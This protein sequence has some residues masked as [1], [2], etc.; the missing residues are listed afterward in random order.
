MKIIGIIPARGGSK[1]VIRKNIRIID[2]LPLIA[3]TI[4]EA[5]KSELLDKVVVSTEDEEISKISKEFGVQVIPR[6][7]SLSADDVQNTEV[8]RHVLECLGGGFSHIV[9]LQPTSPLRGYADIDSCIKLLLEEDVRSV[10]SV[11][12]ADQHPSKFIILGDDK[13]AVPYD[14]NGGSE[15]RRQDLPLVYRQNGAVYAISTKNFLES[16]RFILPT[17]KVHVMPRECSIDIDSEFDLILAEQHLKM[18]KN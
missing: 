4:I 7:P 13:S 15:G 3:Y 2:G 16:N 8:V 9:L 12:I 5:L 11:T 14:S 1:G 18:R 10:F 6:P 17:C